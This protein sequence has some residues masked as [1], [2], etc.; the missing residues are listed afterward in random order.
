MNIT[1]FLTKGLENDKTYN[2][3][4]TK[5]NGITEISDKTISIKVALDQ[6][7]VHP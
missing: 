6:Q 7:V 5:P 3:T 4:L 1:K 2:I